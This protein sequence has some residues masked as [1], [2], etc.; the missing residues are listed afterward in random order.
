MIYTWE[1]FDD[2]P[3]YIMIKYKNRRIHKVKD[4]TSWHC[5]VF[6]GGEIEWS[7]SQLYQTFEQAIDF[8]MGAK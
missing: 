8:L 3:V 4:S 5:H 6:K 7:S 1:T 2:Y